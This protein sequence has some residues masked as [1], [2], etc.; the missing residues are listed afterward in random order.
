MYL[1]DKRSQRSFELTDGAVIGRDPGSDIV[2]DDKSVS[3]AHAQ[4]EITDAGTLI[5][6]LGSSR[7]TF[8]GKEKVQQ[9]LITSGMSIAFGGAR[10][11]VVAEVQSESFD[12]R[13]APL[14]QLDFR[15][16]D[17]VWDPLQLQADYERLR[18][19]YE[20]NRSLGAVRDFESVLRKVL[21]TAFELLSA[22]RGVVQLFESTGHPR[23]VSATRAGLRSES[24]SLS[25][26]VVDEVVKERKGIIVADAQLHETFSRAASIAVEG[27]RSVMCVPVLHEEEVLGVIQVDSLHATNA[28]EKKDLVLFSAIAG[29][30][31]V[32]IREIARQAQE[33]HQARMA[34]VGQVAGGLSR[35][36]RALLE[37]I[38]A[39]TEA[40]RPH[41]QA[42]AFETIESIAGA[43]AQAMG[44]L[45]E[46]APFSASS[47]TGSSVVDAVLSGWSSTFGEEAPGLD[48]VLEL[49]APGAQVPASAEQLDGMVKNLVH[50][51]RDAMGGRGQIEIRT[52]TVSPDSDRPRPSDLPSAHYVALEVKDSGPGIPPKVKDRLFEPF[53]TT[54]KRGE[55]TGLGLASVLG[56][57]QQCGGQVVVESELG[58]GATFRI[59]LPVVESSASEE[60]GPRV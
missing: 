18:V 51:A 7:G 10:F 46:L 13:V 44:L 40:V 30:A 50:N 38:G 42:A 36:L 34:L 24:M 49:D 58:E 23:T 28:F 60:T 43:V 32:V 52:W 35:D 26:T 54:K 56:L 6:D 31:A 27:V 33:D 29:Q 41:T 5:V 15:P 3:R 14:S 59:Y 37:A 16:A 21:E 19:V 17:E 57:V 9:L 55:G 39:G 2:I 8:H 4:V 53:F 20:L 47:E 45:D 12:P 48:L 1:I 11:E 22:E 25:R